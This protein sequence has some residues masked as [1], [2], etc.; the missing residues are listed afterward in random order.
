MFLSFLVVLMLVA[1]LPVV[2][3][4]SGEM[5]GL[6][7]LSVPGAHITGRRAE[8]AVGCARTLIQAY[9]WFG[10]GAY[11]A[12]LSLRYASEPGVA[13]PWLYYATALV[14]TSAPIAYLHHRDQLTACSDEERGQL[15]Q[16]TN[17]WRV[18][19]LFGCMTFL[20]APQLM[21]VP[22]GW[23]AHVEHRVTGEP[24]RAMTKGLYSAQEQLI[25][26][27]ADGPAAVPRTAQPAPTD[28]L[29]MRRATGKSDAPTAEQEPCEQE[30]LEDRGPD[31]ERPA[32]GPC[33]SVTESE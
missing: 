28:A 6:T 9:I 24:T 14:V 8:R 10:W 22:Y 33:V 17:L 20:V 19:L 16:G 25:P 15:Q 30:L 13:N 5:V 18:L 7:G 29:T 31:D 23:F 26:S 11:C 1:T 12:W 32:D 4:S 2:L 3:F 27:T 21:S